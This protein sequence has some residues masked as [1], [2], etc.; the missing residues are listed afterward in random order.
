[1]LDATGILTEYLPLEL[2]MMGTV[3][4]GTDKEGSG[5]CYPELMCYPNFEWILDPHKQDNS[6]CNLYNGSPQLFC[7]EEPGY[8]LLA[9]HLNGDTLRLPRISYCSGDESLMLSNELAD[10]LMFSDMLGVVKT[11][12]T[13]CDPTQFIHHGYTALSFFKMFSLERINQRVSLLPAHERPIIYC[14]LFS[15]VRAFLVHQDVLR[16]WQDLKVKEVNF[17]PADDV[18]SLPKLLLNDGFYGIAEEQEFYSIEK[19]QRFAPDR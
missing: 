8:K 14:R 11:P 9:K 2:F 12:A 19:Y 15:H 10:S 13:I 4:S 3:Y 17:Q 16:N 1:M 7:G 5:E 6:H 18:A